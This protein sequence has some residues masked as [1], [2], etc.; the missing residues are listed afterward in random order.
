MVNHF[1]L[2]IS[3]SQKNLGKGTLFKKQEKESNCVLCKAQQE[4]FW[5]L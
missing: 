5:E 1:L 2:I 3:I 4:V